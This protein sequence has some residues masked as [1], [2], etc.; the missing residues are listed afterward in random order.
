MSKTTVDAEK[1]YYFLSRIQTFLDA[2]LLLDIFIKLVS[3]I[4][5]IKVS[6]LQKG[7]VV[8]IL[9]YIFSNILLNDSPTE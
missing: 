1:Q 5:G 9:V 2:I 7:T 3:G 4:I 6:L 8:L